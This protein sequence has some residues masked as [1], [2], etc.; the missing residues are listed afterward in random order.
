MQIAIIFFERIKNKYFKVS[1]TEV[2]PGMQVVKQA[3]KPLAW[4]CCFEI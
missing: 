4:K 2:L 3:Y 1:S